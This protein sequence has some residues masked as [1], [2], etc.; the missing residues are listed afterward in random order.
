MSRIKICFQDTYLI[1]IFRINNGIT[2]LK[3]LHVKEKTSKKKYVT[4]EHA[5][6]QRGT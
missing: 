3:Q 5:T 1:H 6:W 4:H 2:T